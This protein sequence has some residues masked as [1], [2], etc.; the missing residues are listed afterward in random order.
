MVVTSKW[1]W[2]L[3]TKISWNL[4]KKALDWKFWKGHGFFC[5]WGCTDLNNCKSYSCL[6]L[7]VIS[8][9]WLTSTCSNKTCKMLMHHPDGS[10]AYMFCINYCSPALKASLLQL[11]HWVFHII[12][13]LWIRLSLDWIGHSEIITSTKWWVKTI[14]FWKTSALPGR[15]LRRAHQLTA[16]DKHKNVC[17]RALKTALVYSVNEI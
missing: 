8:A 3:L 2:E 9:D 5:P 4:R 10:H 7:S 1:P 6:Q 13:S 15:E 11:V 12:K 17:G 16:P 14:G